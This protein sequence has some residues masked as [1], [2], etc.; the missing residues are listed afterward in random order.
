MEEEEEEEKEGGTTLVAT[1]VDSLPCTAGCF[2]CVG[3]GQRVDM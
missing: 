1:A 2:T 3:C